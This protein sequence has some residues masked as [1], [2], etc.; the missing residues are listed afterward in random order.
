MDD[1][2]PPTEMVQLRSQPESRKK[3]ESD[4]GE[5]EEPEEQHEE[6][7]GSNINQG[8]H[9]RARNTQHQG[10]QV[11]GR[12]DQEDGNAKLPD[13]QAATQP[14][15][16]TSCQDKKEKEQTRSQATQSTVNLTDVDNQWPDNASITETQRRYYEMQRDEQ[17]L[18]RATVEGE[19]EEAVR[20]A[21][22]AWEKEQEDRKRD[23]RQEGA[24]RDTENDEFASSSD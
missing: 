18:I 5:D 23:E 21:E 2:Q 20:R 15:Q 9:K 13:S 17:C 24:I 14:Y 12:G 11:T 10:G 4:D 1:P 6:A 7:S 3:K 8:T 16:W 19:E 22:E